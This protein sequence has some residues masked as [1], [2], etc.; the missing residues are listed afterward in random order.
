[1]GDGARKCL[2]Y[3]TPSPS[4]LPLETSTISSRTAQNLKRQPRIDGKSRCERRFKSDRDLIVAT[5]LEKQ[6]RGQLTEAGPF[7]L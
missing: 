1:M 7:K 4:T 6:H 5:V 3:L 2:A